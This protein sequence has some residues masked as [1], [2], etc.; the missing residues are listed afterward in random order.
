MVQSFFYRE[1]TGKYLPLLL[2]VASIGA[3]A[4]CAG[5]KPAVE[6]QV[7]QEPQSTGKLEANGISV[8]RVTL[9]MGG[10]MLDMR[11]RVTD[12]AKAQQV[13][14]RGAKFSLTDQSSGTGNAAE[15]L[16]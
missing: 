5:Q 6:R 1:V 15:S 4:G 16:F 14:T 8:E 12:L 3:L 13:L 7:L 10:M 2:L 11:Y 9:A